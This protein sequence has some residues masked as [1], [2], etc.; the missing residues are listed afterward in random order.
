MRNVFVNGED[1]GKK[2][3]KEIMN[4]QIHGSQFVC[5]LGSISATITTDV[6]MMKLSYVELD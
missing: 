4:S 1:G 5:I 2:E 3:R 6:I